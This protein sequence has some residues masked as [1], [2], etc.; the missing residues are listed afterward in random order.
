[1][2]KFNIEQYL[3]GIY[4]D[5]NHPAAYSGLDKLHRYVK[6]DGHKISKSKIRNWLSKQ[7]VYNKHKPVRYSFKRS[8]VIVPT[9]L[10]QFDS[11]TA[12]MVQYSKNNA[13]Y[14]YI[15]VLI[16]ILSRYA[17]TKPLKT[18]TGK[19]MVKALESIFDKTPQKLRSDMGTEYMNDNVKRYLE[20]NKIT[21]FQSLNEKKG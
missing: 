9:K 14:K 11:D 13:G 5:P 4:F 16:D 21:H 17:W 15:L 19:E 7:S 2:A 1:M 12:S 6:K 20:L 18:L 3:N 8:R 10:Y